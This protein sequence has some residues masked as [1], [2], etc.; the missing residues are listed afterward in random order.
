MTSGSSCAAQKSVCVFGSHDGKQMV[1]SVCQ[2]PQM[3]SVAM[4][5]KKLLLLLLINNLVHHL[6]GVNVCVH[7]ADPEK[8]RLPDG[9]LQVKVNNSQR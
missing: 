1:T 8:L 7:R 3:P 5:A 2:T 4:A 9:I 6:S